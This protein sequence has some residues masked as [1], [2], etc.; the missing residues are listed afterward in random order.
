MD[1]HFRSFLNQVV[2][3]YGTAILGMKG[4]S[5]KWPIGI[6]AEHTEGVIEAVK[7]APNS[8]LTETARDSDGGS[9][10]APTIADPPGKHAYPI[11]VFTFIVFPAQ[12]VDPVKRNALVE[13]LRSV[14]TSGQ[15]E[16]SALD[17]VSL[18]RR[19]RTASFAC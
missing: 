16:C 11:A 7:K 14:L 15:K 13:L 5:L 9:G 10:F 19:L 3:E 6:G 12:T 1:A 18:P 2:Q 8:I 4:T 17:Y